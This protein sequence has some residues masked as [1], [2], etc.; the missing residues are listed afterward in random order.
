MLPTAAGRPAAQV[1]HVREALDSLRIRA[2]D[3]LSDVVT[4]FSA[5]SRHLFEHAELRLDFEHEDALGWLADAVALRL[6]TGA[7][8]ERMVPVEES[9][10]AFSPCSS[11][12]C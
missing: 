7:H 10:P 2:E 8:D 1:R 3:E 6:T 11:S 5:E 4:E 9:D 12:A